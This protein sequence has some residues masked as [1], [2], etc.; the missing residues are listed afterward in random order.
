[1]AHSIQSIG[2]ARQVFNDLDLI[3]FVCLAELE[4][5]SQ[6]SRTYSALRPIV[7]EWKRALATYAPGTIDLN[8]RQV[9][10][11]GPA[12]SEFVQLLT[13]IGCTLERFGKAVSAPILN[14]RCP[15][16]GVRFNEYPTQF[17]RAAI[18]GLRALILQ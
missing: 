3:A 9:V 14:D 15:A 8:L 13:A 11:S 7:A 17:L 1:M 12:R 6:Q 4:M 5:L 10:E 18:D 2:T 16:P